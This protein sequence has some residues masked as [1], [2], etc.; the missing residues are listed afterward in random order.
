MS[1]ISDDDLVRILETWRTEFSVRNG[2]ITRWLALLHRD[3]S[4][5]TGGYARTDPT[6]AGSAQ[7]KEH[8]RMDVTGTFVPPP[9]DESALVVPYMDGMIAHAAG[10]MAQS[11]CDNAPKVIVHRHDTTDRDTRQLAQAQENELE[12]F[13]NGVLYETDK[14]QRIHRKAAWYQ[15]TRGAGVLF[16][17]PRDASW[18][19]PDRRYFD[20]LTAPEVQDLMRRGKAHLDGPSTD[21]ATKAVESIDLWNARR[22]LAARKRATE[23]VRQGPHN[24]RT[25]FDIQVFPL[26]QFFYEEDSAGI[27]RACVSQEIPYDLLAAGGLLATEA[28]DYLDDDDIR[29]FGMRV[30][31]DGAISAGVP[32]GSSEDLPRENLDRSTFILTR[33]IDREEIIYH[34]STLANARGGKVVWS[35]PHN[36]GEVPFYIMAGTETGDD[37]PSRA[38]LPLLYGS[39]AI[40]PGLNSKMTLLSVVN[41]FRNIPR[42]VIQKS[43]RGGTGQDQGT[44]IQG[45]DAQTGNPQVIN[46][47]DMLGLNPE[48]VAVIVDG[49]V[50]ELMPGDPSGLLNEIQFLMGI[51]NSILPSPSETGSDTS[52]GPA[53][54]KLLLQTAA[55]NRYKG[56]IESRENA[57]TRCMQ[58]IARQLMAL[59]DPVYFYPIADP[60][61]PRQTRAIIRLDPSMIHCDLRVV[62]RTTRRDELVVQMQVGADQLERG[63]IDRYTYYDRFA[64]EED[65]RAAI[66]RAEVEQIRT[67]MRQGQSP[68]VAPGSVHHTIAMMLMGSVEEMF[69]QRSPAFAEAMA[70]KY[71]TTMGPPDMVASGMGGGHQGSD[72][73]QRGGGGAGNEA[74]GIRSPGMGAALTPKRLGPLQDL[75]GPG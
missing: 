29:Q 75:S 28:A 40:T 16:C 39:Y 63:L 48:Q 59:G 15:V 44:Q 6:R 56:S 17:L 64:E 10:W 20:E 58:M 9:Y 4:I 24:G 68:H 7:R 14:I 1:H 46:Y 8:A 5:A 38:Y 13:L 55:S 11:L 45:Q 72:D 35:T 61:D 57:W 70:E 37:S 2:Q 36:L 23:R 52:S 26:E 43:R 21:P 47:M 49:E 53:W 25:L 27:S 32:R 54:G 30:T 71:A 12:A 74:L 62:Q 42:Y 3:P 22:D 34:V 69:M 67:L 18:G 66:L 50:K 51:Q 31:D 33:Y 41:G 73:F 65:P 19:L 60:V